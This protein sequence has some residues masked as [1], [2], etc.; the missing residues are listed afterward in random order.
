MKRKLSALF[1]A[2]VPARGAY[3][4]AGTRGH[5]VEHPNHLYIPHGERRAEPR[6]GV[7]ASC[8]TSKAK[9]ISIPRPSAIPATPT[10][11]ASGTRAAT[12]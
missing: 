8:P 10:A 11:S 1:L 7:R 4:R 2:R 12:R 6:G 5:G 3:A 9:A